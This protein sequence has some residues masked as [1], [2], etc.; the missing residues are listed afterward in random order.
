MESKSLEI[1]SMESFMHD[2]RIWGS[3][4][5]AK[6]MKQW[7]TM[8]DPVHKWCSEIKSL[9]ASLERENTIHTQENQVLLRVGEIYNFTIL[10]TP[11]RKL[12]FTRD[13]H[14]NVILLLR[15][16]RHPTRCIQRGLT[17]THIVPYLT[18]HRSTVPSFP[19]HAATRIYA[20]HDDPLRA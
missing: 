4:Y 13:I 12:F 10:W 17:A 14:I 19:P 8:C 20:I 9:S 18:F 5:I 6:K 3:W 2:L 1:C 11:S 16:H 15:S 7:T